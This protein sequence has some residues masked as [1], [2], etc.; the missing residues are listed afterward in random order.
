VG[1]IISIYCEKCKKGISKKN[2]LGTGFAHS[3]DAVF[4]NKNPI[5]FNEVKDKLIVSQLKDKLNKGAVPGNDYGNYIYYCNKCKTIDVKFYFCFFEEGETLH[6]FNIIEK[7][8]RNDFSV[9]PYKNIIFEPIYKCKFCETEMRRIDTVYKNGETIYS[10]NDY[11]EKLKKLDIQCRR[12]GGEEFIIEEI[13]L[14][15]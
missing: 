2:Y 3:F 10:P 11:I 5:I 8:E 14:W 9:K 6:S 1:E 15:D 4:Y 7:L 12:C 13:G